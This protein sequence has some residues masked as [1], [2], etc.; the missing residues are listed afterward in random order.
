MRTG[1]GRSVDEPAAIGRRRRRAVAGERFTHRRIA[2]VV[3]AL[4]F[5]ASLV[6]FRDVIFAIPDI[7]SGKRVL[8][9][10]ELV[11]FFN[12]SS[13][14]FEQA[15]GKFSE[16]TNG[17][18]FRV[19]YAFL[20]TWLRYYLILPFA[21]LLVL[22]GIV[23][24]AYLTTAW[25]MRRSFPSFSATNIYLSAGGPTAVMYMIMIYAKATHF[26]TLVLGLC[27]MMISAFLTLDALLFREQRWG[28]RMIAASLV[29]L[30]NPAVHYLVLF[31]LFLGLAIAS[32]VIGEAARSIRS[33][34]PRR[35]WQSARV[36]LHIRIGRLREFRKAAAWRGSLRVLLARTNA[37]T[38]GKCA[39]SLVAL[40]VFALIPYALFVK[41]VALRG[42]SNLA[43]TV[44]GD[45]YFI[46]DASVSLVHILSW[47][48][49]GIM[50]KINFGDYLAKVPRVSSLVYT[51]LILVPIAVPAVRRTLLVGRPQRQLFGVIYVNMTFAVWASVGYADPQWF[52]T[53]HR[54]LAALT[55]TVA[56]VNPA[57]GDAAMSFAS[58][59]VQVLRFPHR[60]QLILFMLGP[61]LLAIPLAWALGALTLRVKVRAPG[62]DPSKRHDSGERRPAGR[63][64]A[65][66]AIVPVALATALNLGLFAPLL[67]NETY[68][69]AYGT[70]DFGG[71][72][73]A[74][75][76]E[77]LKD[78][79]DHLLTLPRGK[80]VVLP[81]TETAKLVVGP[82]H[83]PHKFIDKFYIYY[84][85]AP[86]FYYGLTG[87]KEN[88]FEF[89]L[90][91]RSLY[92]QQDWWV[93]IARDIG[94]QYIVLN[95]QVDNNGGLGAEYLPRIETYLRKDFEAV[96]RYVTQV[97]ENNS[98]VLYKLDDPAPPNRPVLLFDT[99]WNRF[100]S[101]V[102]DR[103]DLSR[104]YDFQ[105]I[106][107]FAGTSG[108]Q[109]IQLIT[110][111]RREA[112]L[113]IWSVDHPGS[114]F[115]PTANGAAFNPDVVTSAYYLSPMFRL[116]LMFSYTKF[117]RAEM[118]TPGI[119]GALQSS[120]TG[121]PRATQIKI[122]IRVANPGRYR[123]LVRA[124][125]TANELSLTSKSLGL[126]TKVELRS[127]P[128]ALQVFGRD[129]VYNR[130]RQPTSVSELSVPQLERLI[131]NVLVPVN[132]RYT[133][134]DIGV[135]T[136]E[137]GSHTV[138]ID[139]LDT[140][141][142][143]LEGLVV[144][145]DDDYR[146]LQLPPSIKVVSQAS[147][148]N[149]SE[150]SPVRAGT[151][152][153]EDAFGGKVNQGPTLEQLLEMLGAADDVKTEAPPASGQRW[154]YVSATILLVV[155]FLAVIRRRIRR[156]RAGNRSHEN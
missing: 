49:A 86:S 9:G 47:D 5:V 52:P 40:V 103:L 134:Q 137:A 78:L 42:V 15:Q 136:A 67:S 41:F 139:K 124:A 120:F 104:C 21:V 143:L 29:T 96:P 57:A 142:M 55:R 102:Y 80:T 14:L 92:Y 45:Y 8:V 13:Q 28:R 3:C 53:F 144:I 99:S 37:T 36:P 135:V 18:E 148:L 11:P 54:S 146:H 105:Y 69:S 61:L 121:L 116:F 152:E 130:Q 34:G 87:D 76:V 64:I 60:F 128:D 25:F 12:P 155:A 23:S 114:F 85:D 113:D 7:I 132:F 56:N 118:L 127:P 70:G 10:D 149:C 19:R 89:F 44:P 81:P 88:K 32:L 151:S 133:Y 95:K 38:T 51:A 122:P 123:I 17:Y 71:F 94:L 48:L 125:T 31:A 98:F 138:T 72:F 75:P 131:P 150:K 39:W 43:E 117:N 66:N 77:D 141:P 24:S 112:A 97:Y 82:D 79:K 4:Y 74:Y 115:G 111:D 91:L 2:F 26:Y 126:Q 30:F 27:L 140:N 63:P 154:L 50:D 58:T 129:I 107:D 100:L 147:D 33:N 93:N 68:R 62:P 1:V 22:P 109:P 153:A 65:R 83:V 20:T 106:S 35:I 90:M 73:S 108:G 101:T 46:R 145:P 16:L 156:R 84:L 6:V 119:F 59:I 110:D